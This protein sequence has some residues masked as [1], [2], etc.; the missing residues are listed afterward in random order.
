MQPRPHLGNAGGFGPAG[1]E[2]LSRALALPARGRSTAQLVVEPLKPPPLPP[3]TTT[4]V[5]GALSPYPPPPSK[6]RNESRT[7]SDGAATAALQSMAGRV[8]GREEGIGCPGS[9]A[10]STALALVRATLTFAT[11]PPLFHPPPPT[12][13][14]THALHPHPLSLLILPTHPQKLF[15]RSLQRQGRQESERITLSAYWSA[16]GHFYIF[17]SLL[18]LLSLMRVFSS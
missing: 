17:K 9:R 12:P 18:G 13:P 8:S 1:T 5:S 14:S 16:S 6:L 11:Q 15:N 3:S 7:S 10:G 4:A 2:A